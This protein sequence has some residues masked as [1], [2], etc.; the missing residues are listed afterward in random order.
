MTD[1][2]QTTRP[3]EPWSPAT[4]ALEQLA[5][6]LQGEPV[7]PNWVDAC[8]SIELAETIDRSLH[9][10][11]TIELHYEDYTEAGTFKGIMASLGCGLLL[12]GLFIV[13]AV[14][15]AEQMGVPFLR[16][17]PQVLAGLL[18]LFLVLQLLVLASRPKESKPASDLPSPTD[19]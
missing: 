17:W 8:R 7:E 15:I 4:A 16:Y 19:A 14:G 5:D 3:F 2:H 12:L 6:A 1:E 9:R 18:G 10:Q 11:R 13:V